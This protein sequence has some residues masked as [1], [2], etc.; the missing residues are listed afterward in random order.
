MIIQCP[1]CRS[2][3]VVALQNGRKV[4]GSVGTV[5][6]AA[7]GIAMASSGARVGATVGL[8]FGP[9]GSAIG[10]I[11]GA[12]FGGLA[13]WLAAWPVVKLVLRWAP[14]STRPISTTWNAWIAD[15]A[16]AS[17]PSKS[18][19]PLTTHTP[20]KPAQ[21]GLLYVPLEV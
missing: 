12:V 10:G 8:A 18:H 13:V 5:A 17:M 19:S 15:T 1:S 2:I 7:S 6:G 11:A 20:L 21:C 9:A 16:S 4:G 3:R 14:S